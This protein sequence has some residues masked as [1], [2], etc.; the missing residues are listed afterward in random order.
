MRGVPSWGKRQTNE[1]PQ[2]SVEVAPPR[3]TDRA[4][5][6]R[7][8]VAAVVAEGRVRTYDMLNLPG[9]PE[10]IAQGAATTTQMTD[11]IVEKLG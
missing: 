5:R 3:E 7:D 9:G 11:A 1:A 10:V 4:R 8:A 2:N 6:I